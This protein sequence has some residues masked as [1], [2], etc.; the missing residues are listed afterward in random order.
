MKSV[1]K[2]FVACKFNKKYLDNC[3]IYFELYKGL[4]SKIK[5]RLRKF[6]QR[7]KFCYSQSLEKESSRG[8][9]SSWELSLDIL[10][11]GWLLL[12][13]IIFNT[14]FLE[15]SLLLYYSQSNTEK[16]SVNR[17]LGTLGFFHLERT[18][19]GTGSENFFFNKPGTV[20]DHKMFFQRTRTGPGLGT[21]RAEPLL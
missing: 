1:D 10:L 20:W 13:P 18:I 17:R 19:T 15:S 6:F 14:I 7:Q 21:D 8:N 16:C 9:L 2:L 5:K 12:I 4:E 3:S 11:V